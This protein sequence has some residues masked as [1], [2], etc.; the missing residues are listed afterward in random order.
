M[1]ARCSVYTPNMEAMRQSW[2]DERLDDG[3]DRIEDRFNHVD[4]QI[5]QLSH[6]L[7]KRL[8]DSADHLDKRLT[9]SAE[10]LDKRLADSA[11]HLE[12]RLA[13]WADHLDKRLADSAEHL[14]RRLA[15]FTERFSTLEKRLEHIDDRLDRWQQRWFGLVFGTIGIVIAQQLLAG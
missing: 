5:G 13:D 10:Y 12:R 6:T 3:F 8:A 14:E 9:D 7:D 11:D 1:C 15:D 2:T 4:A